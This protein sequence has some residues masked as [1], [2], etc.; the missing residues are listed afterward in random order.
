MSGGIDEENVKEIIEAIAAS[1]AGVLQ[2]YVNPDSRFYGRQFEQ[3]GS[4]LLEI[5]RESET[6]ELVD[7]EFDEIFITGNEAAVFVTTEFQ[8]REEVLGIEPPDEEYTTFAAQYYDFENG[9]ITKARTVEN[10]EGLL[11]ALGVLTD[12]MSGGRLTTDLTGDKI[13]LEYQE[14]LARI[15]RHNIRNETTVIMG[16]AEQLSTDESTASLRDRLKRSADELIQVAEKAR[17]VEQ[18]II[19]RE[20]TPESISIHGAVEAL[21]KKNEFSSDGDITLSASADF[22]LT[23]DRLLLT[24]AL[25]EVIE[26][27]IEHTDKS[28]PEV[29]IDIT[30]TSCDD[31]EVKITVT[32]N[33][34]GIPDHELEPLQ[35]EQESDLQHT[36]SIGLWKIKWSIDRLQGDLA[37]ETPDDGGTQVTLQLADLGQ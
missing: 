8:I 9:T 26:N 37:F 17:E 13:R 21:I 31:Y 28:L 25:E 19:D 12:E 35:A 30:E 33:G 22:G 20:V 1:D 5:Y 7:I 24:S 6:Y 23:T 10:R 15:L 2:E 18:Q 4:E 27:A 36:S 16:I 32:D 34:P 3:K 11:S 29:V 14:V